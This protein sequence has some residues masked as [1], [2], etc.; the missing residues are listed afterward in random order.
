MDELAAVLEIAREA[1]GLL[2][3]G[4]GR[5]HLAHTKLLPTD[6]VTDYDRRSEELIVRRLHA[7]FPGDQVLAEEGGLSGSSSARRWL[8]DPLDG[9]TN[10]AHGLP[11]FSVSI[12]LEVEGELEIGVVAAPALGWI[13]AAQRGAGATCNGEPLRVSET[14]SLAESLLVT[15]FPYDRQTSAENNLAQFVALQQRA[16]GVRRLGS[17]AL[18]LALVARGALDG[19]WEM[20]LRPWDLAAG[21]LLVREAGGVVTDW[22]GGGVAIDRGA[23]V[24]TNGRI[25][26]QLLATLASLGIPPSAQ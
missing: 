13:F 14:A 18:D 15:G 10:F 21:T 20:K 19:Y 25:H 26:T 17:A 11:L 12:A 5:H 16:Q 2:Q 23:A 8:V 9:T 6:L 1:A 22:R 3:E 4:A 7:A 24:A